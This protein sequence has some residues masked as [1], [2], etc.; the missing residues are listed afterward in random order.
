MRTERVP[1]EKMYHAQGHATL[2]EAGTTGRVWLEDGVNTAG[3]N[4]L[5]QDTTCSRPQFQLH[6][7]QGRALEPWGGDP[8]LMG[9]WDLSHWAAFCPLPYLNHYL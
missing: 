3:S 7:K 8:G 2:W 9:L 6:R 4:S 1:L 5:S